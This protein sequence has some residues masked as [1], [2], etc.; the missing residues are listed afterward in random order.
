[1]ELFS[2]FLSQSVYC[3]YIEKLLGLYID[4]VPYFA[5]T[6]HDT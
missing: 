5:D 2:W 4:F 3:W 1:M 6:A